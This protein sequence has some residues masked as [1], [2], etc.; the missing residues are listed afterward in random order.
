MYRLNKPRLTIVARDDGVRIRRLSV[1]LGLCAM[2]ALAIW[3]APASADPNFGPAICSSRGTPVSGNYYRSLTLTGNNYVAAATNRARPGRPEDRSRRVPRRLP[4]GTVEVGRN[5]L[6]GRNAILGLG[7]APGVD[8]HRD[9]PAP[10]LR[11]TR[12]AAACSL[13]IRTRCT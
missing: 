7:C 8:F 3:T 9:T 2:L 12:S 1:L 5:V 4:Y 6:V 10:P 11:T 13:L